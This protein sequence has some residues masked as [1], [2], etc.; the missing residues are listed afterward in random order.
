MK[1]FITLLVLL[2][3]VS[4][5]SQRSFQGKATYMS[6][7][8]VDMNAFGNQMSE[9]RKKQ[10]MARMKNFLEKTYI[11]NFDQS[12]SSFKED[13]KLEAP[14]AGRGFRWG[15]SSNGSTYKDLKTRKMIEDTEFFGKRF[16]I[17]EDMEQ[18]QWE[19]TGDTKKIGE[20][21]CY[22]ATMVKVNNEFDWTVFRR[23]RNRKQDSTKTKGADKDKVR[24]VAV[25]AWYTPQIPVSTGPADYWGLPGL[26]MEINA[27]RT[28]MLLT[29]LVINPKDNIE[30]KEPTKGKEITREEYNKVVKQKTEEMRDRF[31]SRR[32]GRGRGF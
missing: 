12:K 14:G 1:Q 10:I 25:T 4:A 8:T 3:S 19:L 26:I 5:F 21:T 15:G 23:N 20:Y 22:K 13:A 28:T 32:G 31:R 27:G 18:P 16:L 7:T 6:K 29:E 17:K 24:R 30:I 11:L 9:Q 2:I